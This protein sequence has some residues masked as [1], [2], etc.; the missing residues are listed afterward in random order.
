MYETTKI[1]DVRMLL[2][3]SSTVPLMNAR[4]LE[5]T[6]LGQSATV[7]SISLLCI[8]GLLRVR[9]EV[10]L[11]DYARCIFKAFSDLSVFELSEDLQWLFNEV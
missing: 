4:L 11:S 10:V 1:A 9:Y 7:G 8:V 3:F 2:R 5:S 6:Y